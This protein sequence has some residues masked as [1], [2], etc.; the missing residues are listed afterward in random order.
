LIRDASRVRPFGAGARA[1][2]GADL[3]YSE[4]CV[5]LSTLLRNHRLVPHG[6]RAANAPRLGMTLRPGKDPWAVIREAG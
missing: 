6:S 2:A 3:A 5:T 4:A 1:C